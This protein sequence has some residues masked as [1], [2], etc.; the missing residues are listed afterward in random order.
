V[1]TMNNLTITEVKL[2]VTTVCTYCTVRKVTVV[3]PLFFVG[4]MDCNDC[5]SSALAYLLV[6]ILWG[7]SNPFIKHAQ[8][9]IDGC[10]N[11]SQGAPP[12][13]FNKLHLIMISIYD[14]IYRLM[15]SPT[16][17][18]PFIINQSGS[19]VYYY[20][21]SNQPI[22]RASPICNSLTFMFTA[23]TG[24]YFFH[25][26]IKHPLC[27]FSGVILILAGICISIQ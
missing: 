21:L 19:V 2:K 1:V 7:C 14:E 4:M 15:T 20:L 16:L 18:I 3:V 10:N 5:L 9:T 12:Y 13:S 27:L 8:T 6:G 26:E 11:G 22:T 23:L 25:E 24:H 17:L